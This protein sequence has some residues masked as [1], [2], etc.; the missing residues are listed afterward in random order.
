MQF[1]LSVLPGSTAAGQ[2]RKA[3]LTLY[4][5][6]VSAPGTM[7]VF[8]S[9]GVWTE[10][11]VNGNN[12]PSAGSVVAGNVSVSGAGQYISIDVTTAV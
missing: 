3:T 11:A 7:N 1:D 2:V 12:T 8:V 6:Q 9:G 10:G 5:N 4:A